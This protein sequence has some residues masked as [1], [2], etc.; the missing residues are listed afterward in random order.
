MSGAMAIILLM[1]AVIL[2]ALLVAPLMTMNEPPSRNTKPGF[3]KR[4]FGLL[5]QGSPKA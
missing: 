5:S 1:W 3:L 4:F 2:A